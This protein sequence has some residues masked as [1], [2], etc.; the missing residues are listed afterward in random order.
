MLLQSADV[1]EMAVACCTIEGMRGRVSFVLLQS[2]V[3]VERS[4][5][6]YA[7][8]AHSV[9]S[10]ESCHSCQVMASILCNRESNANLNISKFHF[11]LWHSSSVSSGCQFRTSWVWLCTNRLARHVRKNRDLN[12]SR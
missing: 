5:A 4:V 11:R 9:K 8:G 7:T 2:L 10:G 12:L 6:E 3:A 1:A